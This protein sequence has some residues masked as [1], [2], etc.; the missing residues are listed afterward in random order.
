MKF[1]KLLFVL[2][3]L[4]NTVCFVGQV[5]PNSTTVTVTDISEST[6]YFE[7]RMT[8]SGGFLSS[9][10]A[11]APINVPIRIKIMSSGTSINPYF[12]TG[13]LNGNCDTFQTGSMNSS[14]TAFTTIINT[15]Y[16]SPIVEG[17]ANGLHF[18][19]PIKLNCGSGT[20]TTQNCITYDIFNICNQSCITFNLNTNLASCKKVY[21]VT[22]SFTDGTSTTISPNFTP[23]NIT[24]TFCFDKNINTILSS[25]LTSC[26]CIGTIQPRQNLR[27]EENQ[28]TKSN[29]IL[30]SPNPTNSVIN[31]EGSELNNYK[32]SIYDINGLEILKDRKL[33]NEINLENQKNGIYLYLITNQNNYKQEG[34]IIKE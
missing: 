13:D 1:F 22:L 18:G 7:H 11:G 20:G 25:N 8:L 23:N 3:F 2:V 32:I 19:V 6:V 30:I 9:N 33:E 10:G 21:T 12:A 14:S 15:C 5:L 17:Q 24:K 31:F 27:L 4:L 29:K 28:N 16:C 34:K 26:K